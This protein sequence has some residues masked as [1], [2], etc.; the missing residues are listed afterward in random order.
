MSLNRDSPGITPP[1]QKS[2]YTM[3]ETIE[4]NLGCLNGFNGDNGNLEMSL[5]GP[6]R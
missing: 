5:L 6:L 2:P 4:R 1:W 3:T